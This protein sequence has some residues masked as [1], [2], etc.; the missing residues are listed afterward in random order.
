MQFFSRELFFFFFFSLVSMPKWLKK[1]WPRWK[2]NFYLKYPLNLYLDYFASMKKDV[3][4]FIFLP[5]RQFYVCLVKNRY[6]KRWRFS[7]II[8]IH[9][10]HHLKI[11]ANWVLVLSLAELALILVLFC[12]KVIRLITRNTLLMRLFLL[13][14]IYAKFS[15]FARCVNW[16]A[17]WLLTQL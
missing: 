3:V 1:K 17:I 16:G 12:S 15:F 7:I 13:P 8:I 6:K 10:F 2:S 11:L 4:L 5:K 9:F 14:F